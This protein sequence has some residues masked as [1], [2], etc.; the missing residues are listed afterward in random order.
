[1]Y[2]VFIIIETIAVLK[3]VPF[4]Q[5]KHNHASRS[6][7]FII[8]HKYIIHTLVG[9]N[10]LTQEQNGITFSTSRKEK[11]R[12]GRELPTAHTSYFPDSDFTYTQREGSLSVQQSIKNNYGNA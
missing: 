8:A 10:Y 1:M 3:R 11:R 12:A 2:E 4:L 5:L 6:I 9:M 7:D